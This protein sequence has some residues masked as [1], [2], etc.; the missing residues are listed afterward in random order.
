MIAVATL[1]LLRTI[2]YI[3]LA[4]YSLLG[5]S[6]QFDG[7]PLSSPTYNKNGRLVQYCTQ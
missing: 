3:S 1:Q 6:Q 2:R 4:S 5:Q 7:S